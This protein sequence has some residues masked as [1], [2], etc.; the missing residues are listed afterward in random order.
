MS[1]WCSWSSCMAGRAEEHPS[2]T[3]RESCTPVLH[4]LA[5]QADRG[6][7]PAWPR[8]LVNCL[9]SFVSKCLPMPQLFHTLLPSEILDKPHRSTP[10][11]SCTCFSLAVHYC[12]R[13][14]AVHWGSGR[15]AP[16]RGHLSCALNGR[17]W[18]RS[19]P[20]HKDRNSCDFQGLAL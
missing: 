4:S 8:G 14:S 5:P 6:N 3:E 18:L 13:G 19:I 10:G 9:F 1:P 11:N 12:C 15:T 17:T 16:P 20:W 7:S 2:K